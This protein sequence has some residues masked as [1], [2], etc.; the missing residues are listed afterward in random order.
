MKIISKLSIILIICV[1]VFGFA[2]NSVPVT[3][4]ADKDTSFGSLMDKAKPAKGDIPATS[5]NVTAIIRRLLG[6]LE[7]AAGLM[8]ILVIAFTGF[9]YIVAADAEMKNE[10]KKKM[11]PIIIGLIL[12]FSAS[13]IVS[14]ILGVVAT[15]AAA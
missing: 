11:L 4:A 9:Q 7:V 2:P 8:S 14:F 12:V 3:Y 10:M 5:S 15:N 6:F 1:A 13:A